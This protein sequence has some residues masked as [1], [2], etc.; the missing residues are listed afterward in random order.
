MPTFI[1]V[2]DGPVTDQ[3]D[4]RLA[5]RIITAMAVHAPDVGGA[6]RHALRV[7]R[8]DA[9]ILRVCPME[10]ATAAEIDAA[11][12]NQPQPIAEEG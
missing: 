3:P 1:V 6:Q 4:N 7:T 8:G 11:F 12:A 5:Q 10:E 9:A 2:F